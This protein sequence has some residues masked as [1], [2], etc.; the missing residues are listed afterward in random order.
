MEAALD[1]LG[2]GSLE[3][4]TVSIQGAGSVGMYLCIFRHLLYFFAY[5]TEFFL[6]S[7]TILKI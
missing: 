3:G 7:K 2:L 5:K 6:P 4:K 1:F